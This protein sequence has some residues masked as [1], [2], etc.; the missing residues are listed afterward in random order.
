MS[1]AVELPVM[2]TRQ[3]IR[4][5]ADADALGTVLGVWA[6]PDDETY[7]SA[8]LMT[9]SRRAG[10][11]VV[12]IAATAGEHGTDDPERWPPERLA[13]LRRH[14]ASAAT[15]AL[16]VEE[17]RWLD[18]EDG[19]LDAID[20]AIGAARVRALVD[21][22]RPDTIVSF[23]PE[24][25]TGHPDHR[26]VA[27]WVQT[28]WLE[29]PHAHRLLQATTTDG[30]A[31]EFADIHDAV[32]VFGPGLPLRRPESD[33]GVAVELDDDLADQKLV[34]LRAHASQVQPVIDLV[35]AERVRAWF[36]IER[37]R[38]VR[39]TGT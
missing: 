10:R 30:F 8:G 37:F 12:C 2:G 24:G 21:E 38:V 27:A 34:A 7:L 31:E 13:R 15:A 3:T 5:P 23:G 33:V 25:M 6:H 39:P 35:G 17:H 14:E 11:R 16:G 32:P 26:A 19:T 36:R 4:T 28:A 22:V 1:A 18:L 9:L 20:P 29:T